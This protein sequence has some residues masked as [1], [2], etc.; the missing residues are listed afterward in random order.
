V[1]SVIAVASVVMIN[2]FA[3]DYGIR[4]LYYRNFVGTPSAPAEMVVNF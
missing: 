4:M 2:H 1:L 3:G